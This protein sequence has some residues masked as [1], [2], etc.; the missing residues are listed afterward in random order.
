MVPADVDNLSKS[1]FEF[2]EGFFLG[3]HRLDFV[4]H[5]NLFPN[6]STSFPLKWGHLTDSFPNLK[7]GHLTDSFPTIDK[8]SPCLR[9][10]LH[11]FKGGNQPQPQV[12]MGL[13]IFYQ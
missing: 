10:G 4:T 9:P 6:A 7:W 12:R 8:M 1:D 2:V 11:R 5:S 13:G 3:N